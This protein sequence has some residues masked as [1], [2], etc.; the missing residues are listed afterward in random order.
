MIAIH[1]ISKRALDILGSVVGI[2]LFSPVFLVASVLIKLDSPGPVF[3]RQR[4]LGQDGQEFLMLKFRSMVD[5]AEK[6]GTG[7]FSYEDDP[8]VT[9]IGRFLRSTSLDEVPQ[10]LN[11]LAGSMSLVGPRPPVYY[12]LGNYRDFTGDLRRR[13]EMKPGIVGLA[14]IHGRNDL[15]WDEKVVYDIQ[16]IE[17]FR[18]RGITEDIRI[19]MVAV[20][21]VLSMKN[22]NEVR[23]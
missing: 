12:E 15:S 9:R 19:L 1:N 13:F 14:Q 16:Y 4:R 21:V 8:R 18:R 22:V 20:V 17:A 7:L 10:F 3:F 23:K 5:G 2:V 11:V 6:R